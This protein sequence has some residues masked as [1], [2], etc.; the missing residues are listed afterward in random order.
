MIRTPPPVRHDE[1]PA[2]AHQRREPRVSGGTC[3]HPQQSARGARWG[4]GGLFRIVTHPNPSSPLPTPSTALRLTERH[5]GSPQ[6]MVGSARWRFL[7]PSG[8]L[9]QI[10]LAQL[11]DVAQASRLGVSVLPEGPAVRLGVVTA[12]GRSDDGLVRAMPV[13]AAG[14]RRPCRVRACRTDAGRTKGGSLA[15]PPLAGLVPGAG[16]YLILISAKNS[17]PPPRSMRSR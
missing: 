7:L 12:F 4:V 3:C 15:A 16:L 5:K 8:P 1:D 14:P 13:A 2:T 11:I 17:A 6:C 10:L 9:L